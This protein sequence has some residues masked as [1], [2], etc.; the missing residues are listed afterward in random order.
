[1]SVKIPRHFT[2][3]AGDSLTPNHLGRPFSTKDAD[4]DGDNQHNCAELSYGAWWYGICYHSN[5]CGRYY[6]SGSAPAVDGVAWSTLRGWSYSFKFAQ[7][8]IR[9][10][11]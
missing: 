10:S 8:K 9:P 3:V 5:L 2:A 7:M 6:P 4:R 11:E 1:M